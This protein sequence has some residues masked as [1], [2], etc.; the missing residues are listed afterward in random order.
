[1]SSMSEDFPTPV[2]PTSRMLYGAFVLLLG[3][4]TIP[5]LRASSLLG[6]QSVYDV[7]MVWLSPT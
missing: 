4:L 6:I 5:F 2:S 7:S 3:I 1:M